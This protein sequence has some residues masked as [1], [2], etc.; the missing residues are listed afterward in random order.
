MPERQLLEKKD[1]IAR[2][3]EHA[4]A[5]QPAAAQPQSDQQ[6]RQQQLLRNAGELPCAAITSRASRQSRVH[7][8]QSIQDLKTADQL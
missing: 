6:N 1:R 4:N 8:D 3:E 2:H 7:P 5:R